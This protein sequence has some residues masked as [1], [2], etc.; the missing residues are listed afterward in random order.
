M[1][2]RVETEKLTVK[3][4]AQLMQDIRIEAVMRR[5]NIADVVREHLEKTVQHASVQTS[6][7]GGK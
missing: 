7:R 3:L 1:L 2:L 6:K 4:P 5:K